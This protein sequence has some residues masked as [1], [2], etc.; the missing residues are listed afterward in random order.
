MISVSPAKRQDGTPIVHVEIQDDQG[1]AVHNLTVQDAR[2]MIGGIEKAIG[3]AQEMEI[4]GKE[5]NGS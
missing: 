5:N 4:G 1:M 2:R 3:L